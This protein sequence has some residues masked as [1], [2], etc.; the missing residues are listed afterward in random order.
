MKTNKLVLIRHGQSKWNKLNKFT[1][2]HDI[3]LSDNGINEALKAGSLLKKE[4][5]FFD[6]AHTSMLKR[7]IHTLRYILDTLDQSWLPVQKSWRLNERHYGALEGL[8]KDEM[9]SKYG[10]EQVNLWRRSFEIIPPQIRLN[11]KRF[12]G[13]DIRY[14]NIDNNELPLGESLEL[15]AKRVIPYWNKFI[16]PQIKKRNRV[17]IVAHG[18]SLRAL[19]QFLNKIDNKKIL[20]LNIPTATPII[21]EFN[22]EYNSI[23]WYYL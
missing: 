6:Y 4:K 20:E 17:L 11:D 10:E 21:L 3:E 9:I 5:F 23:K 13:N 19:I 12:P 1:G 15:T 16:L 8:N 2:W 18:N 14:S 22:E 7:A